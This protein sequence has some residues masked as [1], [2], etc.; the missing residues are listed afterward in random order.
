MLIAR[1]SH[2][3]SQGLIYTGQQVRSPF[4]PSSEVCLVALNGGS[5]SSSGVKMFGKTSFRTYIYEAS[6]LWERPTDLITYWWPQNEA[7]RWWSVLRS[8]WLLFT[9]FV[10]ALLFGDLKTLR[11]WYN[12]MKLR[13]TT[14]YLQPGSHC[15]SQQQGQSMI[16][17]HIPCFSWLKL[18]NAF[19]LHPAHRFLNRN[20]LR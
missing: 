20:R 5:S 11:F 14:H 15:S 4:A 2:A 19:I 7:T 6:H 10:S 17:I 16:Q 18:F 1:T 3:T 13:Y 12:V 8:R 9:L